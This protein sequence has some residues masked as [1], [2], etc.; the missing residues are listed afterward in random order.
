MHVSSI[1]TKTPWSDEFQMPQYG[2]LSSD[3]DVDVCVIGA[4]LA[5][6]STAY[7]LA[8]R[9][10][11]VVVL[12]SLNLG[13][14]QSGQTTAHVTAVL[15]MRYHKLLGMHGAE[16]TRLVLQSHLEALDQI[17]SIIHAENMDC[18]FKR[19]NGYLCA[20]HREEEREILNRELEAL[21]ELGWEQVLRCTRAPLHTFATGPCL[22]FPKQIQY[23]PLKYMASLAECISKNGGLIHCQTPVV[24]V[25]SGNHV[26]VKTATGHQ[27]RARSVVVATNAPIHNLFAI[28][29]KQA[30]YRSY[31]MSYAVPK[32]AVAEGLYWDLDSPYHYL[33]TQPHSESQDLLIIGGEDHKTGQTD[34]PEASFERLA[35]WVKDRFPFAGEVVHRWSGQV[36]EPSDG[37]PYLGH[38]PASGP[39]D[40]VITGHS[41]TGTVQSMLGARIVAD[42]IT[43][44]PNPWAKLFDPSRAP[45]S[46]WESI[47][48]FI[49]ENVNVAAQYSDWLIPQLQSSLEDLPVGEGKVVNY[50]LR[51]VAVY[52]PSGGEFKVYSAAC[53]HLAGVVHWNSTEKSWDCPCH[54]SR[55]DCHGKVIEGP[56]V[57]DLQP[58]V[59]ELA[60]PPGPASPEISVAP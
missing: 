5:G 27:V 18:E 19:L 15:D 12:E 13:E 3:L 53:P 28:H 55:F 25:Q 36:L 32:G 48:G 24:E 52:R 45:F 10:R 56:A 60:G 7:L 14:G 23:N 37:L 17:E 43:G 40:Y 46:S 49:R 9:G 51:K 11:R 59:E 21:H 34:H 33:R 6:L 20:S 30:P 58:V 39:N 44:A 38:N 35:I 57:H 4:G 42:Q 2:R 29:T 41:G 22:V 8:L 54:G 47:G 26:N 16:K 31:A 1:S 50:G